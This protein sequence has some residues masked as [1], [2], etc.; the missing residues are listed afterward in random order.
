MTEGAERLISTLKALGYQTAILSG[1]PV[2]CRILPENW[3]LMKYMPNILDVKD[4]VV[5][6]EVKGHIVDGARKALLLREFAGQN[7]YFAGT[8]D[9]RR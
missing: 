7:G 2:F 9:C 8:A 6:G 4:G 3:G 5:T 1:V